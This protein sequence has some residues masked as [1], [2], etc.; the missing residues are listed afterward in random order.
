MHQLALGFLAMVFFTGVTVGTS[1]AG[2]SSPKGTKS[3]TKMSRSNTASRHAKQDQAKTRPL[4]LEQAK[5]DLKVAR[6]SVKLA[7]LKMELSVL[8]MKRADYHY[9]I[10]ETM[11]RKAK[12]F[13]QCRKL[14]VGNK[15]GKGIRPIDI[16]KLKTLKTKSLDLEAENIKTRAALAKIDMNIQELKRKVDSQFNRPPPPPPDVGLLR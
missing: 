4:D 6:R 7:E 10:A 12:L 5:A 8:E 1:M 3:Q 14:E 11:V 2:Q 9:K 16:D 15:N 13:K